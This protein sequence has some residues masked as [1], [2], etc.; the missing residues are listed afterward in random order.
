[1][2]TGSLNQ[3]IAGQ[4]IEP[5]FLSSTFTSRIKMEFT[6]GGYT[7]KT[8]SNSRELDQVIAL[9]NNV[10]LEEFA[11]GESDKNEDWDEF[12]ENCDFLIIKTRKTDEVIAVYRIIF[13][14]NSPRFYSQSEFELGS[15]LGRPG[16]KIE[17][18]RACVRSDS[19]TGICI[20]LLWKGIG[21]LLSITKA[22]YL[23]G[24]SSI[25]TFD[26]KKILGII[27]YFESHNHLLDDKLIVPSVNHKFLEIDDSF[28]RTYPSNSKI[29][30]D[31]PPLLLSY[32]G[33]GA[34]VA[35]TPAID[36]NFGCIDFLT[37]LD[38]EEIAEALSRK[39]L[40][41]L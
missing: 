29:D 17:L 6:V 19:R 33:V 12:D 37:I 30:D 16:S 25:Q 18:S 39:Y 24:L 14:E 9:R 4:P 31:I 11:K 28:L 21:R 3:Q 27:R 34:K 22:R 10:F 20:H 36:L 23:F 1:M 15:F 2:S 8:A 35:R 38:C 41:D 7:I 40:M 5:R 32:I 13:S 26:V